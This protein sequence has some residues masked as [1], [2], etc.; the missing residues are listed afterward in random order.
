MVRIPVKFSNSVKVSDELKEFI[1]RCLE[2]DEIKRIGVTEIQSYPLINKLMR[3]RR[4]EKC[5]NEPKLSLKIYENK[6][7]KADTVKPLT[8]ISNKENVSVCLPKSLIDKNN[9]VIIHHI[10]T[11]RLLYKI[12]E[13]IKLNRPEES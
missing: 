3:D 8:N 2:V 10:N 12:L 1:K 5:R 9:I 4:I 11:F 13:Q 6:L 7:H